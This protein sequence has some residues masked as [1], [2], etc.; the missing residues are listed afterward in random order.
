MCLDKEKIN[1]VR[2]RKTK[3]QE[4]ARNRN[5]SRM[6]HTKGINQIIRKFFGNSNIL[7]WGMFKAPRFGFKTHSE[8]FG[9]VTEV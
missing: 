6:L 8:N 1:G 2:I 4:I 7:L 3:G 5:K 9:F